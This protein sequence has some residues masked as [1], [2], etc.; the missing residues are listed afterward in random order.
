M[1]RRLENNGLNICIHDR[2]FVPGV[3]IAENI[4]N[5]IHNSRQIVFV[6]TSAFLK[7]YWCMFELNMARMESIY[8]RGGE[9]IMLLVLLDKYV[10]KEM[11]RSLMDIV[12]SKS[13][14]EY[15]DNDSISSPS[16]FW[17]NLVDAIQ[18][19]E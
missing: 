4:T 19:K 3:D 17:E 16:V 8:T 2:D 14:L 18:D 15:P 10:I 12:E 9:N 11:P 7:S 6:M 1:A 13:Y 5:A